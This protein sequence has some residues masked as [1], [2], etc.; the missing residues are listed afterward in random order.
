MLPIEEFTSNKITFGYQNYAREICSRVLEPASHDFGRNRVSSASKV[1]SA[2]NA[3]VNALKRSVSK[4][5]FDVMPA[6]S[7]KVRIKPTTAD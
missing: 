2:A 1:T 6:A 5:W 3:M 4:P 7:D